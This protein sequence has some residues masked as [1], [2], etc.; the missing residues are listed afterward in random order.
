MQTPPWP[1]SRMAV[2]EAPPWGNHMSYSDDITASNGFESGAED[3][4]HGS[5][6]FTFDDDDLDSEDDDTDWD[7]EEE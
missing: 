5:A 1:D 6:D 4:E 3:D 2:G 7:E